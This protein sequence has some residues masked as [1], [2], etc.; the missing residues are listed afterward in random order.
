MHPSFPARRACQLDLVSDGSPVPGLWF[1]S[2]KPETVFAHNLHTFACGE[3]R[4]RHNRRK[5]IFLARVYIE[6][7]GSEQTHSLLVLSLGP[8][9]M[10]W[11]H[12]R[13]PGF[14]G[15]RGVGARPGRFPPLPWTHSPPEGR[16]VQA[17]GPGVPAQPL[18]VSHP[19]VA[20]APWPS[21][22]GSPGLP[23]S[24]Y[25]HQAVC[26]S[27]LRAHKQCQLCKDTQDSCSLGRS[28]VGNWAHLGTL[29]SPGLSG[30]HILL[31]RCV[32]EGLA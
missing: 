28:L 32:V 9:Q 14:L 21:P 26:H 13:H 6:G 24:P 23:L 3:S 8:Q 5:H 11:P 2:S 25:L 19:G 18:L 4:A 29:G 16:S 12:P 7:F 15:I 31:F 17:D 10:T 1:L 27:L 20:G 22:V 30:P